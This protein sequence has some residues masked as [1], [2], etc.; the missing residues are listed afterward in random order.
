MFLKREEYCNF[1]NEKLDFLA[2]HVETNGSLNQ[3]NT[4]VQCEYFYA[5]LLNLI[6]DW[7]L[8]STN[9]TRTN[10]EAIDLVDENKKICVQVSSQSSKAKIENSLQS[11][12][13]K[14]HQDFHFYFICILHASKRTP[15]IDSNTSKVVFDIKNDFFDVCA[16]LRKIQ[17]IN[18]I[19]QIKKIYQL[20]V[21]E[22]G[23]P[24]QKKLDSD[25]TKIVSILAE[26]EPLETQDKLTIDP[27]EVNR[28][29]E[30]NNL[31]PM[32]EDI[33]DLWV[34]HRN[35]ETIY[36]NFTKGGKNFSQRVLSFV[37][38]KYVL[39]KQTISDPV[40]LFEAV[41]EE[42]KKQILAS[43]NFDSTISDENLE[44]CV[45]IIA[46]D[47]F[48]R[49]KIFEDPEGYHYGLTGQH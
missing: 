13:I 6:F 41:E 5:N 9:Q 12:W 7:N 44:Y 16:L 45:K 32:K 18:D 15:I 4:H 35:L 26:S 34:Y 40:R 46:V 49:C 20:V 25:L 21:K 42:I 22:L 48:V 2:Y 3:L 33:H 36:I 23:E 43:A 28:K 24:D 29:I 38:K 19:D 10:Y 31:S 30:F 1:I 39:A 37:H 8:I 17:A 11:D 27:Y 14:Q 47:C